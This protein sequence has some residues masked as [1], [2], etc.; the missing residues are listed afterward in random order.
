MWIPAWAPFYRLMARLLH[1]LLLVTLAAAG[2]LALPARA[3]EGGCPQLP[4]S[5]LAPAPAADRGLLWRLSKNGRISY[6]YAT[7]HLGRPS[8][9]L[10][11]PRLSAALRASQ[12]LALEL[13]A[14]DAATQQ[15]LAELSAA[16]AGPQPDAALRDA[17]QRRTRAACLP[18][19][20]LAGL[21][22][23]MQAMTL[24][25]LEAMRDGLDSGFGA[26][27]MLLAQAKALRL[28]VLALETARSQ[29][30]L[31]LPSEPGE[32]LA[33]TRQ[34]LEQ[35]ERDSARPVM[36]RLAE[37][38]EQGDLEDLARYEQWCDCAA[39]ESE[40][41]WLRRLND[42]RNP[43]LAAGIAALHDSGTPVFAAVGALHMTG[44]QALPK[45]L[46]VHGFAVERVELAR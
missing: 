17:L 16:A 32:A 28:R 34:L 44:P 7:L 1:R 24:T 4:A 41:A 43:A 35:L 31:L 10:P 29:L 9:Q 8:W 39:D 36:R 26:E 6:L 37:A 13:D 25:L 15:E 23:L 18:P 33:Q 2:L 46:T 5:A 11:G 45:L 21:H 42:E 27:Q 3:Q 22:P 30:A 40:R 20:A 38:W 12:V 19:Q 14:S